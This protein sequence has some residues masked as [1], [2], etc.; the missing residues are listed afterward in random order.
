MGS[1]NLLKGSEQA[2]AQLIY[3]YVISRSYFKKE[4]KSKAALQLTLPCFEEVYGKSWLDLTK[5]I[6]QEVSFVT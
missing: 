3:A 6:T 5:E 2:K 1:W 4:N